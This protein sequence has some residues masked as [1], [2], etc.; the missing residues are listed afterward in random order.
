V[1]YI[2]SSAQ[3]QVWTQAAGNWVQH[4]AGINSTLANGDVLGARVRTN[5]SVEVYRNGTLLGSR[6]VTGWNFLNSTGRAGVW[7]VGGPGTSFDDFS[8]G[9]LP[10]P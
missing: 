3:L 7:V 5:G 9:T 1:S 8:T 4:G 2:P 6:T 10:C